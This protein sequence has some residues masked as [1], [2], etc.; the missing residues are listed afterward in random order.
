MDGGPMMPEK[1]FPPF[2]PNTFFR[3]V[4]F[5]LNVSEGN[6]MTGAAA[7][8]QLVRQ[9]SVAGVVGEARGPPVMG[10]GGLRPACHRLHLFLS[11]RV[12]VVSKKHTRPSPG[13]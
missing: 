12:C 4:G 5:S 10:G 1:N 7:D 13:N 8:R 2:L 6:R 9:R 3:P 11:L